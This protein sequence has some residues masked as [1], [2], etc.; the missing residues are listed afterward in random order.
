M[1]HILGKQDFSNRIDRLNSLCDNRKQ[2][3]NR[4]HLIYHCGKIALV[5][6]DIADLNASFYGKIS[7]KRKAYHLKNLKDGPAHRSK[8][9]LNDIQL[10]ALFRHCK[11][12]SA[13]FSYF[14]VLKRM[15]PC[16]R[17]KLNHLHD[18]R[19]CLLHFFTEFLVPVLHHVPEGYHGNCRNRRRKHK[20][21]KDSL[22]LGACDDQRDPDIE[23]CS[24]PDC[25]STWYDMESC[26]SFRTS[27]LRSPVST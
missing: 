6:R 12:L 13:D 20:E 26:W 19:R 4:R 25:V 17:Y 15:R 10:I 1:L 3:D 14:L 23:D 22:A 18:A 24:L 11:K 9:R 21:H 2:R 27:A 7:C 8:K 16:H 5:K